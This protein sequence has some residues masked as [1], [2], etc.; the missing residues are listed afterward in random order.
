ML[1]PWA[2]STWLISELKRTM[3]KS[4]KLYEIARAKLWIS[5]PYRIF[6]FIVSRPWP[7]NISWAWIATVWSTQVITSTDLPQRSLRGHQIN[8]NYKSIS[9][10][11]LAVLISSVSGQISCLHSRLTHVSQYFVHEIGKLMNIHFP[12][13]FLLSLHLYLLLPL[14]SSCWRPALARNERTVN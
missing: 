12:D 5:I 3:L 7:L 9:N 8:D 4:V 14:N 6:I 11:T 1:L 13:G 10:R 2:H